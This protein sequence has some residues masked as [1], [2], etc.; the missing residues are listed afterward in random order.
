MATLAQSVGVPPPPLPGFWEFLK[1]ELTPYPGRAGTVA[2]MV[3]AATLVMIIC[4]TFRIPRAF[5]GA[6]YALLISRENLRATLRSA[7]TMLLVTGVGAA[8]L[9]ISA[10]FVI[11]VRV[12]HFSWI[13]VSFF[14]AFYAFSTITNYSAAAIF[15]FMTALGVPLWDRHVSAETNVEDTLR[16]VLASSIG[17]VVTAVVELALARMKPGDD[18]VLPIAERLAAVESL[19]A[20]YAEGGP[21]DHATEKKVIRLGM[22]GTSTLRRVLRHSDYSPH[23][24]LE[25]SGVVALVGGLV[26]V[27][28]T[29]TQV[30][31]EPSSTDQK[32]LRNLA[33]TIASIRS[34]LMNRRIPVSIQFNPDDQPSRGV[35]LV[36]EMEKIV[37]LISQVVA[38]SK[39]MDEYLQPSEDIPRLK[40]VVPDALDNPEH[41]K[42]ALKGCL[43]ASLCYIIYNAIAWPGISTAVTTC[44]LTGLSTIGA[45]RQKGI[46]RIA[47]AVTGG[48][49]I[50]MGSQVFI[51]PYLDS[52][53]G[54]T[55]LFIL[56]TVFSAWFMTSSPRLSY[57]GLQAAL[58][59]YLI[60]LQEFAAQTSLSIARDRVVGIL[61]GLFMMWLVFDHLWGA[62][63]AVEMKK[64]FIS[65]LRSLAQ[66]EREPLPRE[67]RVAIQRCYS[68]R[69]TISTHFDQV[70]ALAD[71]VLFEFGRSRQ[72][73]LALR[74]RIRRWGP[75]LRTLFLIRV[76][77][78][79]YRL[80][81][82]GFDLPE[83]V[84][85]AQQEFDE[86]VAKVLDGM[87][88]RMAGKVSE[89]RDN[90]EQ[91]LE[92]LEET[93]RSCCSEGPQKLLTAEL[94]TFLALSR[95]IESLTMSLSKEI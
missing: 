92:R 73:D 42:F 67:K 65:S 35:P 23:Y 89:R 18:I 52:I 29:S 31:F 28:A 24:R 19:L 53:A 32:Q 38:G 1:E 16:V 49:L 80:R 83:P 4:M 34:D 74:D 25:M 36:L 58:A 48:L 26:D 77:L 44:L 91:S 41:L 30:R 40:F 6:V 50:G 57:F 46:L 39:S 64:T 5:Q 21:A 70:R 55:V 56:V 2:R 12:L 62:R 71:G 13:I 86:E 47:G 59:F 90:L 61:L 88:D 9:L 79:K 84:E 11:N 60:N 17:V 43:A 93:I 20:R 7:G 72:E 22:L 27:A 10:W 69:E 94:Q 8:Y 75:Q 95:S 51:L 15:S 78:L 82:A 68:L 85:L 14:A 81:L 63:A 3:I 66:L 37:T 54:F 87:A 45:S 76:A 33:A